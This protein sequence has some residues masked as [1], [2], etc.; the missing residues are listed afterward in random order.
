[1]SRKKFIEDPEQAAPES[2]KIKY[3]G[4]AAKTTVTGLGSFKKDQPVVIDQAKRE[5]AEQLVKNNRN[6]EEVKS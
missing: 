1:M 6:F 3:T 2:Y 5:Q 4:K